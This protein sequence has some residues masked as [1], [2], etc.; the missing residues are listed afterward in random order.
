ML[1]EPDINVTLAV[2]E[3]RT[4]LMVRRV[5]NNAE[6][7]WVR[8]DLNEIECEGYHALCQRIGTAALHML[9]QSHQDEFAKFPLL[10]PAKLSTLDELRELVLNL[11]RRSVDEKTT[12]Y[13]VAI[14]SLLAKHATELGQT[15]LPEIWRSIRIRV[16]T[17]P[18]D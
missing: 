7:A 11:I 17:R 3:G 16:M 5:S 6:P 14:D 12:A 13:V 8:W 1:R 10:V 18:P 4:V 15:E 2:Y 9:I